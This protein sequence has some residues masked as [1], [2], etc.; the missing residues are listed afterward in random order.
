MFSL[1]AVTKQLS[2]HTTWEQL[3]KDNN[4]GEN[5]L[6]ADLIKLDQSKFA[7]KSKTEVEPLIKD[8]HQAVYQVS[9]LNKK[10][11]QTLSYPPF[12]TSTMQ[13]AAANKLGFSSKQTM[14][15]AQQLY[16]EGFITYYWT[17]SLKYER[18]LAEFLVLK[19]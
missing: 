1:N 6:Y 5:F 3:V 2:A 9:Q 19:P 14:T 11:R 8:C 17:D 15:L 13:Q 7:A 18:T 12:T 16:E 10:Q 4:L